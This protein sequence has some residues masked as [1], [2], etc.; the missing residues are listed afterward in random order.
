[1]KKLFITL[2]AIFTLGSFASADEWL[3]DYVKALAQAKAE[4]KPVLIDFTGSDWC[5]WCMK[6][7]REVFSVQDFKSYA[8]QKLVL[9]KID[10]PRRKTLPAAETAQNQKLSN[11]YRIHGFPTIVVLKPDGSKAGALGYMPGGPKAFI[12][13]LEKV[14]PKQ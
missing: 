13:E 11:Q 4:N 14:T 5:G 12:S 7:D 8:A 1:M 2:A 10:F 9:L 3:T 6:L